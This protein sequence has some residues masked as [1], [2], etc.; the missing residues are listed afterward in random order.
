MKKLL[1]VFISIF[2]SNC[3]E[4]PT[5]EGVWLG[6]AFEMDKEVYQPFAFILEA[7][8]NGDFYAHPLDEKD[9]TAEH[10]EMNKSVLTIDTLVLTS[11][12]YRLSENQFVKLIPNKRYFQRLENPEFFDTTEVKESIANHSWKSMHDHVHFE[13]NGQLRLR[14][15]GEEFYEELCW[16]IKQSNGFTFLLKKGNKIHCDG[17][18]RYPER[19]ISFGDASFTIE[20]WQNGSWM[21]IEYKKSSEE[22]GDTISKP[23]Q[24]CNPYLYRNN[25][26]H[27]YYYKGTFYK[28]GIYQINKLF[29]QYYS[30]PKNNHE[31]G[32]IK[33]EFIVNCE[34][35]PGEFSIL[36][37]DENYKVRP[38]SSAISEQLLSFTKTLTEWNAGQNQNGE[39]I[40]TYRFLT[41]KIRNGEVVE[42]FP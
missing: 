18:I 31:S 42:I 40:D 13:D 5:F 16:E 36:E 17:F 32:L 23:F 19:L 35:K 8:S 12:M 9:S 7:K 11:S 41:F 28:G 14:K 3:S 21:A 24:L 39:K 20:R 27:R 6:T 25:P 38:F 1:I 37:L 10:W 30:P 29:K 22:K 4:V 15:E 26:R 33:V 34:G 2:L